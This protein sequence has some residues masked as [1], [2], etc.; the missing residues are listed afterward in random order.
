MAGAD[1]VQLVSALLHEGPRCL[2]AI[3]RDFEQWGDANGYESVGQLRG[4]MSLTGHQNAERNR[5]RRML[6]S[7]HVPGSPVAGH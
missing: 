1:V 3:R 4:Q 5:Y 7:W 2:T 6:R